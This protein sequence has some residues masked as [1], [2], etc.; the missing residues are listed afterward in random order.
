MKLPSRSCVS[1]TRT[2]TSA[3][4]KLERKGKII[5][6]YKKNNNRYGFSEDDI[7][8]I[9]TKGESCFCIITEFQKFDSMVKQFKSRGIRVRTILID[10]NVLDCEH[11]MDGRNLDPKDVR[12][13]MKGARFDCEYIMKNRNQILRTYDLVVRNGNNV[14][15][16]DSG[17][18]LFNFVRDTLKTAEVLMVSQE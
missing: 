16:E 8:E 1:K 5:L 15:I 9:K 12:N 18:K 14:N 11:R 4:K 17:A 10:V 6:S 7:N 3:I 13:R 2:A